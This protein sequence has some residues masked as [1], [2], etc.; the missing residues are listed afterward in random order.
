[1]DRPA[2]PCTDDR[3]ADFDWPEFDTDPEYSRYSAEP[4]I[5]PQDVRVAIGPQVDALLAEMDVDVDELIRLINAE[6]TI[7]P[8]IPDHIPD[9]LSTERTVQFAPVRVA[10]QPESGLAV[11][12][13]LW[14]KRFLKGAAIA[15]LITLTGGGAAALAMNKSVTVNVDGQQQTV[16]TFGSTVGDV[17]ESAGIT[18]GAHDALSPSPQAEVGDG[19]VI[20]L[21]R[22]RQL[23]LI[24]DGE[25]R[26]SWVRATTVDEAIGQLGMTKLLD[27]GA[28]VSQPRN[29]AVPLDG[30]TLEI[31]TLKNITVFDG[32][33]KPRAVTTHAVTVQEFLDEAKLELGGRDEV[34]KGLDRALVDGT[35]VHITRT[36]VSVVNIKEPIEAPVKEIEDD[37]LDEGTEKVV[38]EGKA[39]E[40][41]V[42]YRITKRNNEEVKREELSSKVIREAEAKVIRVGTKQPEVSDAGVWD[43]LAQCESTGNW[44]INTGNGYYGGLQF[45]K[46]TWDAYG[47]DAY[48]AY[49]HQ[50]SREQQ[51]TIA[52]KLRDDRGGY[53]AWPACAR[54]LGLPT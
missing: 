53:G 12:T 36:G 17:L 13:Q 30:M 39:G 46:Q 44:S 3:F 26:E 38:D 20:M 10:E 6:T 34:A 51:I 16:N 37:S 29:S 41:I 9:E 48:A 32:G 7:L 8:V 25:Q 52:T 14:K 28:W 45:D 21:E 1:M 4:R 42:T 47:G 49:P 31:K 43:R 54:K 50:A 40:K 24:V 33:E 23:N 19:G 11:A 15:V 35:E 27:K 2:Y 18:V 5:T 22:G